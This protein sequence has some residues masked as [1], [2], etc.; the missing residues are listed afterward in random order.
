MGATRTSPRTVPPEHRW[1][2]VCDV[3]GRID[4]QATSVLNRIAP[5]T[6][7]VRALVDRGDVRAGLMMVRFFDDEDGGYRAM[8]WWLNPDQVGLLAAM[9]A[10]IDADEYAGDFT[11]HSPD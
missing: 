2:I 9:G 6:Q 3:H 7:Q 10:A 5:V 4:Q 1:E 11:A 8:G